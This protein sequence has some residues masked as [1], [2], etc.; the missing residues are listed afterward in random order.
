MDHYVNQTLFSTVCIFH[1]FLLYSS[2]FLLSERVIAEEKTYSLSN[3][4]VG[5]ILCC[6]RIKYLLIRSFVW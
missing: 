3:T 4:D 5:L 1:I 6:K 2:F